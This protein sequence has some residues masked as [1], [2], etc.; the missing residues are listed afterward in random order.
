MEKDNKEDHQEHYFEGVEKLLEV[1]FTRKD[2]AIQ[3]CDLRKVPREKWVSM[4]K[5]VRCE[6]ISMTRNDTIDAYVLSESSMFVSK[7]R[8]I[9]KTCGTTTP[10]LC[11]KSL[12]YLVQRYAGYD[13]VQDLF[14][15]RKNYKRPELQQE[16]H[17]TFADEAAL[18]DAMFHDGAA[19]CLG[20]VNRDCWYLYTLN[21]YASPAGHSLS[22]LLAGATDGD[23]G[24]G[25]SDGEE[26]TDGSSSDGGCDGIE[27]SGSDG[28]DSS[29]DSLD[30]R[31]MNLSG[32]NKRNVAQRYSI[33]MGRGQTNSSEAD[34]T[35]EIMMSDLDPEVMKIFTKQFS[36]N[37]AEATQKSGIDKILSNV[38][39]DDYLFDPCG[40]SMN[41]VLKNGEY[42]TIHITPEA[43]FSYVS[44]ESNIPQSSYMDVITRVL[45]TFRPGK[46]I[47]TSFANKASVVEDTHKDL[48]NADML[49]EFKRRDIQ[50]CHLKNYDLTYALYSKFPS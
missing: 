39:I 17:R 31:T 46:F 5:I 19:Y 12:L 29:D 48:L 10:L 40:Y 35:L 18:L 16:P 8:I 15:S 42:M 41:G 45:E 6:I 49:S 50:Y 3:H 13:E 14:Y 1:W 22:A 23:D 24:F 32:L 30:L 26:G 47:V 11:L 9:L 7:R 44:F 2:G 34:Q 27:D 33:G 20:A 4:L 25:A 38:T 28:A 43:K 37:A 21:P 36:A